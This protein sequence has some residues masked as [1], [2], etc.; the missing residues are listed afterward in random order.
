MIVSVIYVLLDTGSPVSFV[1]AEI[2]NRQFESSTVPIE[3]ARGSYSTLNGS[4]IRIL[5]RVRVKI[6]LREFSVRALTVNLNITPANTF[7]CDLVL[8]RDV[9]DSEKLT[10][11]Y[12]PRALVE[13][14]DS[15]F[16]LLHDDLFR[17]ADRFDE[18][19]AGIDTDFGPQVDR[20]MMTLLKKVEA[21][22]QTENNDYLVSINLKDDSKF[23]YA[24]RRLALAEK[25]QIRDITDDLLK[26]EIIQPSTSPYCS[27][28]VPVS[29]RNG[30]MRL[31]V[32]LRPLNARVHKQ[33]Y[34]FPLIEDCLAK[35]G[36]RSVFTL[37]DMKDGFH[38]IRV[39][40]DCTKYFLFATPDG[41][42]EFTRL[43]FGFS[44][45]PAEFQKRIVNILQPLIR[46]DKVIVYIDDLLIPSNSVESNLNVLRE[47]LV[48]LRRHGFQ[49][50][51]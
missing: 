28:V 10:L 31:C 50:N 38:Q 21:L 4:R 37:L 19:T 23:A 7:S 44:E 40:P 34:P 6:E 30:A 33:K 8:G 35:L 51:L 1:K 26:R 49:L 22:P 20:R 12:S 45:S 18:V 13:N 32:D 17:P 14:E 36:G 48:L 9:I 15:S 39:H 2:F 42:F 29:K 5:D 43:P 16:V 46:E 11:I 24:P 27:R 25:R 3:A 47:V 41:Q